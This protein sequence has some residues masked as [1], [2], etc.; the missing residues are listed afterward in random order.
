[1]TASPAAGPAYSERLWPSPWVWVLALVGVGAL[2]IAYGSALGPI[3][4]ALVATIGTAVVTGLVVRSAAR[5]VVDADG[6]RAGRALLPW[7]FTGR[8]LAL[9]AE[10]SRI[11]R[12][13]Q[14]DP[15]AYLLMRPGVGPGSVVV[16]VTD[17]VDPH[18]TWLL[19]TRDPHG[20]ARAIDE[21]RGTLSA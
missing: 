10:Q 8:A 9:D 7:Q 6:L 3:A 4:A 2:A 16:E 21:V 12:G 13:P 20:L 5:V 15:S 17:P 19:A 11:A 14:G 1:V 18:R